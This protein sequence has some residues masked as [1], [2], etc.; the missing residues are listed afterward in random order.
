MNSLRTSAADRNFL[1][2]SNGI[3]EWYSG[4]DT[5]KPAERPPLLRLIPSDL[6]SWAACFK[7]CD[8]T[9]DLIFEYIEIAQC[10]ENSVD[11]NNHVKKCKFSGSFGT[12]GNVGQQVLTIKGGCE[13]IEFSGYI[14]SD[15]INAHVVIGAWSDQSFNVSSNLDFSRLDHITGKKL[16]FI[17]GRVNNPIRALFGRPS[18]IILPKNAKVLFWKSL[19][20]Q[21]YWWGKWVAVKLGFFK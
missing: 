4:T 6:K 17:L 19:G 7:V 9:S 11:L 10:D 16:T 2:I 8:G 1:S 15:G 5:A 21:I 18:D 20:Y 12:Q 13:D 3:W 14:C